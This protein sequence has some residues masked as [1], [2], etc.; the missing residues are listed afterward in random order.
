MAV[1]FTLQWSIYI[2]TNPSTMH[3]YLDL[4]PDFQ[5]I[6]LVLRP[7]FH[8]VGKVGGASP[9]KHPA[10]PPPKKGK[11]REKKRERERG[12]GKYVFGLR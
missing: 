2:F 4:T 3:R 9:P 5:W 12:G 8:P 6:S 10:P 1:T 7:R 11:E